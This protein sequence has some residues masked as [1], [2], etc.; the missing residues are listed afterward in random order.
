MPL[1]E[2]H[3]SVSLGVSVSVKSLYS[4]LGSSNLVCSLAS[5]L[6]E[7]RDRPPRTDSDTLTKTHLARP[8]PNFLKAPPNTNRLPF[9]LCH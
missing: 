3:S 7:E 2:L 5:A 9:V 6:L 4:Y 1:P 8:A